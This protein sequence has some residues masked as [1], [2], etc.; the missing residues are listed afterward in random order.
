MATAKEIAALQ[1][2]IADLQQ[3][4]GAAAPAPVDAKPK[5]APAWNKASA[6]TKTAAH[7]AGKQAQA[8]H[9]AG[10]QAGVNSYKKAYDASLVEAGFRGKYVE[11]DARR[12][13]AAARKAA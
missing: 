13:A 8:R 10:T 4:L 11:R 1:K 7:N 3:A 2:Q 5:S 6:A 12:A 9:K